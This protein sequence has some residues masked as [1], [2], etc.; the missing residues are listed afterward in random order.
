M[1]SP[2]KY[3]GGYLIQRVLGESGMGI[4]YLDLGARDHDRLVALKVMQPPVIEHEVY[5]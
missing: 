3:A 1:A 5:R 4:V 2:R